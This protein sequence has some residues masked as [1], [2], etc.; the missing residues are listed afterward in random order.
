MFKCH[1][2]AD[3]L[4]QSNLELMCECQWLDHGCVPASSILLLLIDIV[5]EEFDNEIDVGQDHPPATIALATNIIQS[6][7]KHDKEVILAQTAYSKLMLLLHTYEVA[8]F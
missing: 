5:V 8:M 6:L 7:S 4:M 1:Y 3:T 2:C